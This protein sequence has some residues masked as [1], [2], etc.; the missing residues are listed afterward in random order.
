MCREGDQVKGS[1]WREDIKEA[2][3][4]REAVGHHRPLQQPPNNPGDH[5]TPPRPGR[6]NLGCAHHR[7]Q[8]Q[9]KSSSLLLSTKSFV[10]TAAS[11]S[12]HGH[13]RSLSAQS[14][15]M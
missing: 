10:S 5:Q 1:V 15:A 9:K 14:S 2:L 11:S 12:K 7:L 13:T 8:S 3:K 4:T 6:S